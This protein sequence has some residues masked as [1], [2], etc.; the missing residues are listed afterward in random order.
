[1]Q[2]SV[3]VMAFAFFW[4]SISLAAGDA[5]NDVREFKELHCSVALP[6][7]ECKWI[8]PSKLP[9]CIAAFKDSTGTV[10]VLL[11][12][13]SPGDTTITTEFTKGYDEGAFESGVASKLAGEIISFRNIPCYQVHSK[14]EKD[15]AI[16]TTRVFLA[17][18]RLYQLQAVGSR[19]PLDQ[20][21]QLG[22]LFN[23]FNFLSPPLPVDPTQ[24]TPATA[25]PRPFNPGSDFRTGRI[26]G[27]IAACCVIG[28]VGI[29]LV[30]AVVRKRKNNRA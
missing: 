12:S 17:H 19:L 27:I 1:M 24:K 5:S 14:I 30:R 2:Q 16:G 20:R 15:G 4:G 13:D 22:S 10:L 11:V 8:D 25:A 23:S 3:L 6:D 26:G 29:L 28:I 21:N 9:G 7:K 18:G